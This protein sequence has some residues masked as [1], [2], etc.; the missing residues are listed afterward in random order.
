MQLA[1]FEFMWPGFRWIESLWIRESG[2]QYQLFVQTGA[3]Q[4]KE[5][6]DGFDYLAG[7]IFKGAERMLDEVEPGSKHK[8]EYTTHHGPAVPKDRGY[9]ELMSESVFKKI[10]SEH[11][12]WRLESSR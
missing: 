6:L 11:A 3:Q 1:F 12:P 5:K 7:E 10:A 4:D 9:R 8:I 2:G